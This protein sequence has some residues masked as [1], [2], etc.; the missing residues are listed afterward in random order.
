MQER[1]T[2]KAMLINSVMTMTCSSSTAYFV[3][4]DVKAA[5]RTVN[6]VI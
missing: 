6:R 4:G 1:I 2:A 5:S 3:A